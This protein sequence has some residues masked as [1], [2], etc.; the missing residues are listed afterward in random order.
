MNTDS[1]SLLIG[2]LAPSFQ[3]DGRDDECRVQPLAEVAR[4]SAAGTERMLFAA[5]LLLDEVRAHAPDVLP[6]T[7]TLINEFLTPE[8]TFERYAHLPGYAGNPLVNA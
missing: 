7:L 2:R 1:L 6:E 8:D 4:H 3:K 5:L